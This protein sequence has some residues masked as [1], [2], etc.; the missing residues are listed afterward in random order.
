MRKLPF[1]VFLS[2]LIMFGCNSNRQS[3]Y[4]KSADSIPNNQRPLALIS[5]DEGITFDF[6]EV[7]GEIKLTHGFVYRNVSDSVPLVIDS[8]KTGCGC[9]TVSYP[10]QPIRPGESDTI[11]VTYD[12][13]LGY[14]G[15]FMKS[16]KVFSNS[17]NPIDLTVSG[18]A[19]LETE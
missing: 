11:F 13:A 1:F 3:Q 7:E 6:G 19:N 2:V 15:F 12:T 8:V 5:F 9:T 4:S 10:H 17:P 18:K 16:C 14:N